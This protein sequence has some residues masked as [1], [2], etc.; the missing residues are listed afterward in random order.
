MC[1]TTDRTDNTDNTVG[2]RNILNFSGK[3]DVYREL[4]ERYKQYI[5]N[6]I[7]KK[8]ERLPSVRVVATELGVNPNTVAKAYALL[9]EEGYVV[10]LPKKGAYVVYEAEN[11]QSEPR[12]NAELIK[13][14]YQGK[15]NG[16]EYGELIELIKEVYGVND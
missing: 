12:K 15:E 16:I 4:A 1:Y 13:A 9:E 8:G 10:A 7:Y 11:I 2:V 6:L 5:L 3:Q 14:L